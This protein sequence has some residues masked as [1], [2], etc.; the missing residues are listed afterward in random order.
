MVSCA[1]C[2][3]DVTMVLGARCYVVAATVSCAQSYV[4]AAMVALAQCYMVGVLGVGDQGRHVHFA[5]AVRWLAP[6]G[7]LPRTGEWS[8]NSGLVRARPNIRLS[9]SRLVDDSCGCSLGRCHYQ[10][11]VLVS[12]RYCQLGKSVDRWR[13]LPARRPGRPGWQLPGRLSYRVRQPLLSLATRN[14]RESGLARCSQ[15]QCNCESRR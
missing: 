9:R 12:G 8:Q 7:S 5:G 10:D 11:A 6:F 13:R 4:E 2:Y 3:V 1:Q 14:A 15:I